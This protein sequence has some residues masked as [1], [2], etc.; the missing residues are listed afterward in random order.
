MDFYSFAGLAIISLLVVLLLTSTGKRPR[1]YP[2]G[3]P[4]LPIIGN[5]HQMPRNKAHLQFQRWAQEYGSIYSLILG[6]K[7]VIVLSTDQAVK[8]L[9]DKRGGIY[10]SRPERYIAQDIIS[11]GARVVLMPYNETLRSIRTLAH[12]ILNIKVT[13]TYIP[14][15]DLE[16]KA[17][18][19][20]MLERPD[21]F[22]DHVRRYTTALTTQMAFG[23]RMKT[24]EDPRAR[25]MFDGF[26]S[27]NEL[28]GSQI[29]NILDIFPILRH[30]PDFV[31]PIRRY[32][33][34]LHAKEHKL[35]LDEYQNV[36]KSFDEGKEVPCFCSDLIKLQKKEKFSDTSGA[37][38]SGSF[39]Q[40][41]SETTSAVLLGF[42]QAMVIFPEVSKKAQAELDAV[43]KDRL[44]ELE[45]MQNLP[46]I[47][48][49]VKESLR[50]MPTDIL[51]VPHSLS[52]DDYYNG[53]KIP[54]NA[55]IIF[56]VWTIH[57]DPQRHHNPRRFD[58]SRWSHDNQ[59]SAEAATNPDV[60]KR[61]HFVYGAGRRLCQGMHIADRSMFIAMA[62]LLWAFDFRRAVDK[63]TNEEIVPDM[64]N[65]TE[66]LFVAP[67]PFDADIVP[68]DPKKAA[69][70]KE[71]WS[72]IVKLLDEDMQ[73]KEYPKGLVWNWQDSVE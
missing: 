71:E 21:A 6:T 55:E 33:R 68:R 24:M 15:Q 38:I 59:T 31:L 12:R 27:F 58:P 5:L 37:Y 41:G 46:Y 60:T 36:K 3:P 44:P 52:R 34:Q 45:D 35:F 20:D 4:T 50:W 57:N 13:D 17:M 1:G 56:N 10:S 67:E 11:G 22:I 66:G 30:L 9:L 14:Y 48:A 69:C 43:C 7:V 61:D 72:K 2:P 16:N 65:L 63:K 51:G 53:Y 42:V 62:R 25:Q 26:R 28:A 73:W 70:V 32:A 18:L 39:L 8:D 19:M 29:A 23:F 54:K 64:E 40:A 49:C 47:R